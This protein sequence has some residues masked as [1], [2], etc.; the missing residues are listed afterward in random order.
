MVLLFS[1]QHTQTD[2]NNNKTERLTGFKYDMVVNEILQTNYWSVKAQQFG[3]AFY[4]R[5]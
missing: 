1:S 5:I 2:I 3:P 4:K